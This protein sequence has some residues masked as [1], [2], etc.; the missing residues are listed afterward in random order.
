MPAADP[1]AYFNPPADAPVEETAVAAEVT[2]DGMAVAEETAVVERPEDI[3]SVI[4]QNAPGTAEEFLMILEQN[5]WELVKGS[6]A[7]SE[8]PVVEEMGAVEETAMPTSGSPMNLADLRRMAAA[9]AMK[10]QGIV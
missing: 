10:G 3:A 5:G 4:I 6:S 2:P 1:G 9:N 8:G 7:P